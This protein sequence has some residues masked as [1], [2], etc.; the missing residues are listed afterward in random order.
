MDRYDIAL[1]KPVPKEILEKVRK[2]RIRAEAKI[3]NKNRPAERTLP[4][5]VRVINIDFNERRSPRER[6]MANRSAGLEHIEYGSNILDEIFT[7]QNTVVTP[8]RN[9]ASQHNQ[10]NDESFDDGEIDDT[11]NPTASTDSAAISRFG[12]LLE[13]NADQIWGAPPDISEFF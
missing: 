2:D 4:G 5:G 8:P 10:Q 9:M 11:P 7:P 6:P 12:Q 1:G 13:N 3:G